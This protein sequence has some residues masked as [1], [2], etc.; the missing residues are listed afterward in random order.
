MATSLA[1]RPVAG[2]S[3][4]RTRVL[5]RHGAAHH[6]LA[7]SS[8]GD[9]GDGGSGGALGEIFASRA[10]SA[11]SAASAARRCG[12]GAACRLRRLVGRRRDLR[13]LPP[14]PLP[15]QERRA[16]AAAAGPFA[17]PPRAAAFASSSAA[18][19]A[20][21][22]PP[23]LATAAA[24]C[25]GGGSAAVGSR[26]PM[27]LRAPNTS[28]PTPTTSTNTARRLWHEQ[29]LFGTSNG[30]TA[31]RWRVPCVHSWGCRRS[32]NLG[33]AVWPG[34]GATLDTGGPS[35][36]RQHRV[37]ARHQRRLVLIVEQRRHRAMRCAV[38]RRAAAY[39]TRAREATSRLPS[40]WKMPT[41]AA[42]PRTTP[43][44]SRARQRSSSAARAATVRASRR[45]ARRGCTVT[46]VGRNEARGAATWRR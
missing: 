16:A 9:G 24:A 23:G 27:L 6:A 33:I 13:R 36:F 17:P 32:A 21:T 12:V 39:G 8:G 37:H 18:A 30:S 42:A 28:S 26:S 4:Q 35:G 31:A 3:L 46:V 11:A 1:L 29:Q 7:H 43:P 19:W 20:A 22:P 45:A 2:G 38:P 40:S 5:A 15:R 10:F 44:T 25:G 14:E 34:S 41:L